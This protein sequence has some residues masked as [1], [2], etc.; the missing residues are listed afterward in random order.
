MQVEG[1]SQECCKFKKEWSGK[2]LLT[3]CVL[4]LISQQVRSLGP[5]RRR[6]LQ[7]DLVGTLSP[8][9]ILF[10]PLGSSVLGG[11]EPYSVLE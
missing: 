11:R 6:L 1:S 9:L 8:L 7:T 4:G 2:A 3:R 5:K 10:N